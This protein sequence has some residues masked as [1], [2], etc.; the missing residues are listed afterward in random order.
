[1]FPP[2]DPRLAAAALPSHSVDRFRCRTRA[3]AALNRRFADDRN[4]MLRSIAWFR[5]SRGWRIWRCSNAILGAI[6]WQ[7]PWSLSFMQD[8]MP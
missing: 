3:R 5:G 8:A 7:P 4:W 2:A 6:G 1:M